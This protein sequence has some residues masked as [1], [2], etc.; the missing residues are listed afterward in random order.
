MTISAVLLIVVLIVLMFLGVPITWALGAACATAIFA[1]P[2]LNFSVLCQKI[3]TGCDNFSMLALPAFF[4]AGDI[5]AKGGLSKRLV[6]F[7]DSLVGW[8]SGGISLVSIVACTFFAAISG[9]SV[10]TTAAIGGLM[11]PEMKKRN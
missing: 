8:I 1:D 10:A 5:M 2:F 9:S 4:L 7:A 11:Y 3:F 6:S